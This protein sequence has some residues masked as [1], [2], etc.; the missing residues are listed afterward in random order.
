MFNKIEELIEDIRQ[1]KMV[2]LVDDEDREN[3]GDIVL[4]ADHVTPQAINFMASEAR[5][6]ICLSLSAA[7]IERLKLP[8]M[9]RDDQNFSSNKTAFTVSIEASTGVTT[10]IS[11]ADRT[12][13]IQVA[14]NPEARATD[15]HMPGH[16]FPIR[17]QEGGVLRRAGHT[18]G[19]VDLAILAGCGPSAVICEVMNPDGTMARVPDLKAFAKK[20]DMK[21]G[22]IVDLI[23]YRLSRDVLVEE[24]LS[25]DLPPAFGAFKA[26][27]FRSKVDGLEHLVLQKGEIT[28]DAP[29]TVRVHLDSYTRDLFAL[30]RQGQSQVEAALNRLEKEETAVLL[31]LRGNNRGSLVAEIK[32]LTGEAEAHPMDQRDYGIGAQILRQL[33]AHRIRLVTNKLDKKV[34]LKAYNLEIVDVI[35]ISDDDVAQDEVGRQ[36]G[37]DGKEEAKENES[38]ND[39]DHQGGRRHF[40]IQ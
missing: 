39:K 26:R 30:M 2:I 40:P 34:G 10:G 35:S 22:T 8:L 1:G 9:V 32:A 28:H 27:V 37:F 16:I 18:E 15:V 38:Q 4:A 33:G 13:T 31:L 19:S 20:H 29:V 6:L 17:A 3:E 23:E 24:V 5:G 36:E 25:V 7:Q 14:S 21:I 11:A 12:R